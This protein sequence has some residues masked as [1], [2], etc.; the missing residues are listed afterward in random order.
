MIKNPH[1]L[2]RMTV[3]VAISSLAN[4]VSRDVLCGIMLPAIIMCAKDRV[5]NVK[6]NVAKM[7]EKVVPLV[8]NAVIEQTI[9]PCLHE[10]SDDPDMDV[11]FY[12]RQALYTCDNSHMH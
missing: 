1:Y 4:Y 9:K 10:L 7:L 6:F 11:R 3:L 2:Y 5:P 12:A 8:D